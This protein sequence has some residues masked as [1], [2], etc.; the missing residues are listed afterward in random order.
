MSNDYYILQQENIK[1]KKLERPTENFKNSIPDVYIDQNY[2]IKNGFEDFQSNSPFVF[3]ISQTLIDFGTLSPNNPI[4]RTNILST[5]PSS[6]Y[7]YSVFSLENHG[8]ASNKGDSIPDTTCDNGSCTQSMS[9]PWN[10]LL[11][12]G[13]GYR[14]DDLIGSDCGDGF[15]N[16][17]FYKQ[18]TDTSKSEMQETVLSGTGGKKERKSQITYKVNISASQAKGIYSNVVTYIAVPSF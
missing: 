9:A 5:V 1:N 7:A 13:F 12:Y 8:L 18:F 2:T 6:V 15:S 4:L 14:C 3:S 11:T 16:K 17:S 10:S